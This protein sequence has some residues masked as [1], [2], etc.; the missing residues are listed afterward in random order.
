M[1][2]PP[3]VTVLAP[4]W[5]SNATDR[6]WIVDA[7]QDLEHEADPDG[8]PDPWV[9]AVV[10]TWDEAETIVSVHNEQALPSVTARYETTLARL[11]AK[12]QENARK[13]EY[14]ILA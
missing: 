11:D 14:L 1:N 9:Y 6:Y 4:G 7:F 5:G 10:D 8:Y 12:I 3:L 2:L 13:A